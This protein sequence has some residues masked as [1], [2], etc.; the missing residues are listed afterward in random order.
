MQ[1]LLPIHRRDPPLRNVG[2]LGLLVFFFALHCLPWNN[3]VIKTWIPLQI[4]T[5]II[6]SRRPL[7]AWAVAVAPATTATIIRTKSWSKKT[8]CWRTTWTQWRNKSR[9]CNGAS[10]K[11]NRGRS[12]NRSNWSRRRPLRRMFCN[13]IS[14]LLVGVERGIG[15]SSQTL[16]CIHFSQSAEQPGQAGDR[17]QGSLGEEC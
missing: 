3:N 9:T 8:T 14:S 11:N 17:I 7:A 10:R 6:I 12:T 13:L 2:L 4:T 1:Q 16:I 15:Q 5:P